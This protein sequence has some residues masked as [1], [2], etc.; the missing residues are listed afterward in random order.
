M[1]LKTEALKQS[2][3]TGWILKGANRANAETVASHIWGT[4]FVS[5]LIASYLEY[6]GVDV[7]TG[8][9]L[10]MATLHDIS[11]SITSD[12]PRSAVTLFGDDARANKEKMELSILERLFVDLPEF[13]DLVKSVSAFIS[14]SSLESRIVK[15]SDILDMLFHAISLERAG[16]SPELL[17]E[18]FTSS[19]TRIEKCG[20]EIAE[21]IF[22]QLHSEHC[23]MKKRYNAHS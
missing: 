15:A 6:N 23:D 17:D 22:Q 19:K 7:D 12:I 11:E 9:V 14:N 8:L 5:L 13:G 4:T 16:A 3:R 1:C 20:I 10:K 21:A 2:P 18:F